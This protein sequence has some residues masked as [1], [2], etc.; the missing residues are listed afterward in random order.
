MWDIFIHYWIEKLPRLI[1]FSC[2]LYSPEERAKQLEDNN[3]V[4]GVH[5]DIA[6]KGQTAVSLRKNFEIFKLVYV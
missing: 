5:D 3:D 1:I 2:S 4:C 6:K